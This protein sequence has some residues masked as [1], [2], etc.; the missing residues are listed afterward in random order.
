MTEK[1][2]FPPSSVHQRMHNL[3]PHVLIFGVPSPMWEG[4]RNPMWEGVRNHVN[5]NVIDPVGRMIRAFMDG[6]LG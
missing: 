4:V 5:R 1:A 6:E 3:Q 2:E